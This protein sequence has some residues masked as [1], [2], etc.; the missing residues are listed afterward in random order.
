MLLMAYKAT[1]SRVTAHPEN[2]FE[3]SM[4]NMAEPAPFGDAQ[5]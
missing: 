4:L 5:Q 2:A 3:D 1:A